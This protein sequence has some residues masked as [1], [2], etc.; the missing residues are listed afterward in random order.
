VAKGA[1]S[2]ES[3]IFAVGVVI[4][5]ICLGGSQATG[6]SPLQ[7]FFAGLAFVIFAVIFFALALGFVMSVIRVWT[8]AHK[9]DGRTLWQ[10]VQ[11]EYSAKRIAQTYNI[12]GA[13]VKKHTAVYWESES[14]APVRKM[15]EKGAAKT[16]HFLWQAKEA[17]QHYLNA[18][19]DSGDDLN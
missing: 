13:H 16:R 10:I 12:V 11:Q 18:D 2:D 8:E 6:T 7:F 17:W 14:A 9:Q 19:M 5:V 15:A 4:I 1:G 3:S